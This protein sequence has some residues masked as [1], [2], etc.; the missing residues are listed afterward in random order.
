LRKLVGGLTVVLAIAALSGCGKSEAEK[1]AESG[2]RGPVTCEGD[3]MSGAPQLP[4]GFPGVGSITFVSSSKDGP[5]TVAD[6]YSRSDLKAM[7]DGYVSGFESAGYSV[8]FEELEDHDSE[9][10]YK[11]KDQS[12]SGQVALRECDNGNTSVHITI[13]PA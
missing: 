9:V 2:G 1:E 13:R 7:H 10:S 6:G 8:L 12:K 4:A 3:A 5:T 11:T